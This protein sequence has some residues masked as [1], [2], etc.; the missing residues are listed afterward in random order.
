MNLCQHSVSAMKGQFGSTCPRAGEPVQQAWHLEPQRRQDCALLIP[1]T[2]RAWLPPW[3]HCMGVISAM[4]AK[5]IQP[6]EMERTFQSGKARTGF[7]HSPYG[8]KHK[9]DSLE[10]NSAW[11]IKSEHW[12]V[13]G[14]AALYGMKSFHTLE[15]L[16]RIN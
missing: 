14:Y 15:K 9:A 5:V 8:T 13:P 16:V 12:Y 6:P 1:K 10:A 4:S 11:C 2:V 3:Q 7:K